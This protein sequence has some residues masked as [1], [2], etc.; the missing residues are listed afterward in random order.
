[1]R[2]SRSKRV[3]GGYRRQV[4]ETACFAA[5]TRRSAFGTLV[6]SRHDAAHGNEAFR[7]GRCARPIPTDG[8]FIDRQLTRRSPSRRRYPCLAAGPPASPLQSRRMCGAGSV[9][10]HG[11]KARLPSRP[12]D[13]C[14]RRCHTLLRNGNA[15]QSDGTCGRR[16]G[17]EVRTPCREETDRLACWLLHKGKPTIHGTVG[18]G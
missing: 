6:G 10:K 14:A 12:G 18:A 9:G 8:A 15:C 2:R 1:M 3:H 4:H 11:L 16:Q 17:D 7:P 13:I 5:R